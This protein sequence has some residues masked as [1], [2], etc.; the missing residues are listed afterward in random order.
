MLDATPPRERLID[1]GEVVLR[2]EAV[3]DIVIS[4]AMDP[5]TISD[6]L[7][8]SAFITVVDGDEDGAEVDL[9]IEGREGIEG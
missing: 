2:G 9:I 7:L 1:P 3:G 5:I 8:G 6:A 4:T